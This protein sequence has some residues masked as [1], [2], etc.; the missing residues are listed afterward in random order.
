MAG[1][2]WA[3]SLQ[4]GGAVASSLFQKQ[5][6]TRSPADTIKSTVKGARAAGIHPLAALGASPQYQSVSGGVS[7]GSAIGAGLETLGAAMPNSTGGLQREQ[8]KADINARNAQAE[9]YR[10]QSRTI[11]SRAG[12]MARS[13]V[14]AEVPVPAQKP[15]SAF[16]SGNDVVFR[17]P[18]GNLHFPHKGPH[19]KSPA[20]DYQ[21]WLGEGGDWL[22]SA[23][24]I[25]YALDYTYRQKYPRGIVKHILGE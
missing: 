19:A 10:A 21:Q 20:E 4:A 14:P 17:T 25:P 24:N 18:L 1:F 12:Q 11:L 8:L 22:A 16:Q 7:T 2:P 9:M 15:S 6:K 3:A 23:M 5:P 13:G